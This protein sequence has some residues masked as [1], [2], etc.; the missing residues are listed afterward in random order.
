M[1]Y[2]LSYEGRVA[3]VSAREVLD[4]AASLLLAAGRLAARVGWSEQGRALVVAGAA[5]VAGALGSPPP[6]PFVALMS[7]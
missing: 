2:P 3:R 6:E 7:C 4:L 5:L 1:L